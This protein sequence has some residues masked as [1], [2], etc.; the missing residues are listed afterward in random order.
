MEQCLATHECICEAISPDN[1]QEVADMQERWCAER[2]C[3]QDPH[4][5]DEYRAIREVLDN[6]WALSAFGAAIRADGTIQAYTIGEALNPSTAV[7]HF[8][9]AM[10]SI[11]G[12]YQFVNQAFCRN[13]LKRFE[14]VNREQDLGIP[15]LRKAKMSYHPDRMVEKYTVRFAA[16]TGLPSAA[17]SRGDR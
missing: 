8:E 13:Y 15:G 10:S 6:F 11:T 14:Y 12:L 2:N 7:I 5:C 4:L 1:L 9:K 3:K 16:E 17:P